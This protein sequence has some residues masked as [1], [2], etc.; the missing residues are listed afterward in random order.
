MER[1]K[2]ETTVQAPQ[3]CT[4]CKVRK[5]GCDKGLP[6]CSYCNSRNL[7]CEYSSVS[8]PKKPSASELRKMYLPVMVP[9]QPTPDFQRGLCPS[10]RA[11]VI[12]MDAV[13]DW[14]PSQPLAADRLLEIQTV[15]DLLYRQVYRIIQ[16][17]G[18]FLDDIT[19]HFFQSIHRWIPIISRSRL[20]ETLVGNCCPWPADLSILLLTMCLVVYQDTSEPS[21]PDV[22]TLYLSTKMLFAHIQSVIPI[23]TNLIQA[24]ILIAFFEY[25]RFQVDA[26]FISLGLCI[27]LSLAAGLDLPER[28]PRGHDWRELEEERNMWWAIVILERMFICETT[29]PGKRLATQFPATECYLPSEAEGLDRRT[30][31]SLPLLSESMNNLATRV[32]CFCREVQAALLLDRVWSVVDEKRSFDMEIDSMISHIDKELWSFLGIIME[33]CNG[34]YGVSCG[35]IAITLRALD[36]LHSYLLN[37]TSAPQYGLT[38]QTA[39]DSIVKMTIDIAAS[40]NTI[41]TEVNVDTVPP[42]CGYI[43]RAALRHLERSSRFHDLKPEWL[44]TLSKSA[45][46]FNTRW[47]M[48]SPRTHPAV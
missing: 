22:E 20:Q 42:S 25:A 17:T 1:V 48:I 23:S 12:L 10:V 47:G 41:F 16:T 36:T 29:L 43:S 21:T 9:P 46:F 34:V 27:R 13:I 3:V 15:D 19:I 14:L 24:S 26:A 31:T 39:I 30:E 8:A 28:R 37:S 5:R 40:H 2:R 6:S 35:A 32:D 4:A 38:S 18:L 7:L 11:S 44:K 33:Q 45:K